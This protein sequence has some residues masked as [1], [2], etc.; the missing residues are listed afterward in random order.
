MNNIEYLLQECRL[1]CRYTHI[2]IILY[3][4]Q[5]QILK[6]YIYANFQ[7]NYMCIL[8]IT[9]L[10]IIH[11]RFKTVFKII[12]EKYKLLVISYIDFDL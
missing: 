1:I 12:Y 10:L 5:L 9:V 4:T 7:L 3:V 11:F 8:T 2:K 6:I